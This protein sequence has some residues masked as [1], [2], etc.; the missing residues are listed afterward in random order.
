MIAAPFQTIEGRLWE[1]DET[2]VLPLSDDV[3]PAGMLVCHG[4]ADA[5]PFGPAEKRPARDRA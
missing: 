4:S 1:K 2:A 5:A 3:A